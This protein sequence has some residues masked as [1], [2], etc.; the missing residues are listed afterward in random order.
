IRAQLENSRTTLAAIRRGR[1]GESA[2]GERLVVLLQSADRIF[3]ALVALTFVMEGVAR[4]R[5]VAR[6]V[7]AALRSLQAVLLDAARVVETEGGAPLPRPDGWSDARWRAALDTLA[8]STS[9][10]EGHAQVA[11]GAELLSRLHE[12]VEAAA[13]TAEGLDTGHGP[14]PPTDFGPAVTAEE[15]VSLLGPLRAAFSRDSLVM[16]HALRVG[17]AAAAAAGLAH[18]LGLKRGYWATLTV[19]IVL[20]P[21][22]GATLVKGLQRVG[23]T[24]LGGIMAALLA[25]AVHSSTGIMAVIFVTAV[26]GVALQPLN[27]GAYSVFLTPTF[28]LLAEVGGGDWHLVGVR[29]TNTLLGGAIALAG[30]FLLWP[31]PESARLPAYA[32]A[33]LRA[34]AAYL[35]RALATLLGGAPDGLAD[36]RRGAGLATT[37]AEDSFQRLLVESGRREDELEAWM[38][39]L[40]YVRRLT[41]AGTVLATARRLG[42][43]VDAGAVSAFRA[44]A[45]AAIAEL[46]DAVEQERPPGAVPDLRAGA[47]AAPL[48]R[49]HLERA[50]RQVVVLHATAL[51]LH[52]EPVTAPVSDAPG[53]EVGGLDAFRP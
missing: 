14:A 1:Q 12:Y 32:A 31:S 44:D 43:V 16:R 13:E 41:A 34:S 29:V 11:H 27:Y 2:R 47:E 9:S 38:A 28:V 40:T 21:Y 30:A 24:V 45:A 52:P 8:E 20:Q 17:V 37:N 3:P 49:V 15:P 51:R 53:R 39:L 46:A 25:N 4:G 42:P 18:A 26:L 33:A 10:V 23:G 22:T 48:L 36:A 19:I 6:Q 50:A 7:P 35:D 5:P